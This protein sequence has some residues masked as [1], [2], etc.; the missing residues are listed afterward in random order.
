MAVPATFLFLSLG[1]AMF[2]Y[3]NQY[4]ARLGTLPSP[5]AILPWS[6]ARELPVGIAGLVVAGIFAAAQSTVSTSMNSISTVITIDVVHR[7]RGKGAEVQE[8]RRARVLTVIF[9]LAGIGAAFYLA[10]A[11]VQSMFDAFIKL[12]GLT[13]SALAGLFILGIFTRRAT[14]RGAACG[15]ATGIVVLYL[16]QGYTS[17]TFFTY[18]PIGMLTCIAVGYGASLLTGPNL[19]SLQGLTYYTIDR[20]PEN[21]KASHETIRSN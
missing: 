15:A 1:T 21:E 3:Y 16:V 9:G 5:D 17:L 4:P 12:M 19:R 6:I 20:A 13:G 10:A 18:A 8:L 2:V 7:W 14:A 11:N